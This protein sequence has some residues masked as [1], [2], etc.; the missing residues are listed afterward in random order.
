MDR[1]KSNESYNIE[2]VINQ[3]SGKDKNDSIL[4]ELRRLNKNLEKSKPNAKNCF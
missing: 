2:E 3:I 1:K 4:I